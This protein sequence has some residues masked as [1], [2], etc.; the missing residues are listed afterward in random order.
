MNILS[1]V[2][3]VAAIVVFLLTYRG[4][5]HASIAIGLALTVTAWVFQLIWVT[6]QI[7]L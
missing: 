2:L 5:K 6:D 1:F 4:Y 7:T 3:A